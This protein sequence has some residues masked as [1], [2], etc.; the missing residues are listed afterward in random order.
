MVASLK[1]KKEPPDLRRRRI[2]LQEPRQVDR[3]LSLHRRAWCRYCP[4]EKG[5]LFSA[6]CD[7][8][9]AYSCVVG[10]N[11]GECARGGP[12]HAHLASKGSNRDFYTLLLIKPSITLL[13]V[14]FVQL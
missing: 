14:N 10:R 2:V 6:Y 1:N 7:Q 4:G 3:V 11:R 8:F 12:H 13:F 9:R 5:R